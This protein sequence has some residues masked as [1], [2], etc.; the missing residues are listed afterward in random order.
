M[1]T[2][3][4][5]SFILS[6]QPRSSLVLSSLKMVLQNRPLFSFTIPN[7]DVCHFMIG[8][9]QWLGNWSSCFFPFPPLG[10]LIG[11]L[12]MNLRTFLS[13]CQS[14]LTCLLWLR[15]THPR[16]SP[17]PWTGPLGGQLLSHSP[18]PFLEAFTLHSVSHWLLSVLSLFSIET[19]FHSW[20]LVRAQALHLNRSRSKFCLPSWSL[21]DFGYV[22][23]TSRS[24][25]SYL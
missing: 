8:F 25:F 4:A 15:P 17:F 11:C 21:G 10:H 5:F 7:H 22:C 13:S 18:H 2:F 19:E 14:L 12:Q 3:L 9:L 24:L 23:W 20:L 1:A 6:V 16:I